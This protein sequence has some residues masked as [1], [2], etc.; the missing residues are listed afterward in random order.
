MKRN[1]LFWLS[2]WVVALGASLGILLAGCA[3]P[4]RNGDFLQQIESGAIKMHLYDVDGESVKGC[5][6][7]E[8]SNGGLTRC[9]SGELHY[10]TS[11]TAVCGCHNDEKAERVECTCK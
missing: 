7:F 6:V 11:G 8:D 5:V 2:F 4:Q 3:K 9:Y 1:L 10:G